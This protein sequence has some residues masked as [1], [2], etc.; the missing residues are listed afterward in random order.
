MAK[1]VIIDGKPVRIA[2]GGRPRGAPNRNTTVVKLALNKMSFNAVEEYVHAFRDLKDPQE[3][4]R[5]LEFLFKFMYP[6][7]KE[8]EMTPQEMLDLEKEEYDLLQPANLSTDQLL[9]TLKDEK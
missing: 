9:D 1:T 7:L 3:K 2:T 6:Q 5:A 8:V 4:L